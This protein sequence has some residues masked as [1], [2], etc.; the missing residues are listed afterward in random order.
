MQKIIIKK[1]WKYCYRNALFLP[2]PHPPPSVRQKAFLSYYVHFTFLERLC[3]LMVKKNSSVIRHEFVCDT[4]IR[5]YRISLSTF[6]FAFAGS[7]RKANWALTQ[8]LNSLENFNLWPDVRRIWTKKCAMLV[9]SN[10][11]RAV[12]FRSKG[13]DLH[14][15]LNLS[16]SI[17]I[18]VTLTSNHK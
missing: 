16:L 17:S 5:I 3:S 9:C 7:L 15:N 2:Y 4:T 10:N 13:E 12:R 18:A 11:P 8:K 1:L 14:L 6:C